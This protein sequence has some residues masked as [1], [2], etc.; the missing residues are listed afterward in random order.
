[1]LGSSLNPPPFSKICLPALGWIPGQTVWLHLLCR[2]IVVPEA[3]TEAWRE[4]MVRKIEGM[5]CLSA[6]MAEEGVGLQARVFRFIPMCRICRYLFL[7]SF[8]NDGI[9]LCVLHF[10]TACVITLW[11]VKV[12]ADQPFF[13]LPY[14]TTPIT[15]KS[16]FD[17][18]QRI[19]RSHNILKSK[20]QMIPS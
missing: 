4:R 18:Y 1:M 2:V 15:P 11:F 8:N 10:M 7:N 6:S 16:W 17:V 12:V 9:P 3:S 20:H 19:S 13:S 14:R 5:R